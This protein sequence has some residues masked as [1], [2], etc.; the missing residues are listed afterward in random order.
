MKDKKVIYVD[1][2][3]TLTTDRYWRGLPK[4]EHKYVQDLLFG[5]D[6]ALVGEWMRGKYSAEE[7]NEYVSL[8]T[9]LNYEQLWEIFV[10]DC[11]TIRVDIN[12][13]KIISDLRKNFILVLMTGNMDSFSRFTVPA[14]DLEKYFDYISNSYYEGI[15]KTDNNGE[16]FKIW[17]NRLDVSI[18][19]SIMID[20]QD[21]VCKVFSRLGG[22]SVLVGSLEETFIFLD[23]LVIKTKP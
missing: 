19:D 8:K 20:D 12:L 11:K 15:H 6:R 4:A 22:Q 10:D 2:D 18:N 9:G 17:E 23:S 13:L 14:L 1:F 5:D 16:L 3:G 7:I 21:K